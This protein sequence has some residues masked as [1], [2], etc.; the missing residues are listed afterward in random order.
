MPYFLEGALRPRSVAL[1][2]QQRLDLAR[3]P[4]SSEYRAIIIAAA[5]LTCGAAMLVPSI[6]PHSSFG[7][8]DWMRFRWR[9][10]VR[11]SSGRLPW[12]RG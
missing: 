6:V 5:P 11:V 4:R 12:V 10:Q 7:K 3:P 1:F 8:V 2:A 9:Y